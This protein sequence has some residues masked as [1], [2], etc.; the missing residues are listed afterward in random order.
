M[1]TER[2]ANPIAEARQR[3]STANA[4]AVLQH[5]LG[6]LE[7]AHAATLGRLEEIERQLAEARAR[8]ATNEGG[9]T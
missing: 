7:A 9:P 5:R 1:T 4:V 8:S 2:A 6:Q 3:I